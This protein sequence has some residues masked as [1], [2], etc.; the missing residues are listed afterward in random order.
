MVRVGQC[1]MPDTDGERVTS[2]ITLD[3]I[4]LTVQ[5]EIKRKTASNL[6]TDL[7]YGWRKGPS[8]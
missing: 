6:L 7:I 2:N 3:A 1:N 8:E 5:T 4:C